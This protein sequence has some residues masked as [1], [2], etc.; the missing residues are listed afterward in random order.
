[1]LWA[2]RVICVILCLSYLVVPL[3]AQTSII[4]LQEQPQLLPQE[5]NSSTNYLPLP[6]I[7]TIEIK[8]P[9]K[10]PQ[11][12]PILKVNSKIFKSLYNKPKIDEKKRIR[13]EWQKAFGFD[14]W[15]P[16]YKA[17]DIENWISD[18]VSIKIFKMK[19]R[20]KFENKQFKYV[21]ETKF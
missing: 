15:Y 21:F 2:S 7:N 4:T 18:R 19:G 11:A 8:H 12:K 17:K 10:E 3:F 6:E 1:M 20:A 13:Q 5:N 14:V 16:Y 9:E